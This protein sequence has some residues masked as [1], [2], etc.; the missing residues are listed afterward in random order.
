MCAAKF[1][2]LLISTLFFSLGLASCGGSSGYV[3]PDQPVAAKPAANTPKVPDVYTD[4]RGEHVKTGQHFRLAAKPIAVD[5]P[6]LVIELVKVDW[7][8]MTAPSGKELREASASLVLRRG[9]DSRQVMIPQ[10][11]EKVAMGARIQVLDAGEDYNRQRMTYEPWVELQV[12][13]AAE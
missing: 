11:D 13:A 8:T 6:N 3:V 1:R 12:D 7:Q 9:Q 5:G 2:I 10:K 4:H